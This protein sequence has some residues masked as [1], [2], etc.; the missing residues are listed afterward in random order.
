MSDYKNKENFAKIYN[1]YIDKIY[2]FIFL[3]V[4]SQEEAQ[5]LT[6]ETFLKVWRQFDNPQPTSQSIENIQAFLYK[7]AGNLVI[8]FYRQ[9]PKREIP[10]ENSKIE[11]IEQ[12]SANQFSPSF[13][14]Q[15]VSPEMEEIQKGLK[16][17]KKG[18]SDVIILRY[19]ND[20]SVPEISQIL[21]KSQG[22]VRVMLSR[23]LKDLKNN[24]TP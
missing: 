18:Y 13:A 14:I 3:K 9:K 1:D 7:T 10:L 24:L 16:N 12:K 20:L 2:R 6:S 17:I 11:F 15:E 23:A 4:N 19:L 8:D 22:A 5:D 21:D